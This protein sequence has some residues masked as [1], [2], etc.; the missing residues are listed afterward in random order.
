MAKNYTK[1]IQAAEKGMANLRLKLKK[2]R[3][4]K[5]HLEELQRKYENEH[6]FLQQVK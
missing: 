1:E 4:H 6:Y 3:E 5:E 2:L